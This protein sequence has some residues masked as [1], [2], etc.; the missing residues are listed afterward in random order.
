MQFSQ[1]KETCLYIKDLDKAQN[2]YH[3]LLG[4]PVISRVE[5]RH[6]FFRVGTS[7]LLCF[8][9]EATKKEKELPP[10]FGEGDQHL[11]LE[12][13]AKDYDN[14]RQEFKGKGIDI[15]HEHKW[16]KGHRSFYFHDAENNVLEVV[17]SGMWD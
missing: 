2:F 11:A 17:E 8:V 5:G 3:S 7:V 16:S 14:V 6:I 15:I 12:V 10:H 9:A 1:I 13:E 4:L